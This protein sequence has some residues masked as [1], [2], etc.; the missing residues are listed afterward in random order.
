MAAIEQAPNTM[1]VDIDALPCKQTTHYSMI[2]A[3][4]V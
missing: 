1:D 2:L 4:L 3:N